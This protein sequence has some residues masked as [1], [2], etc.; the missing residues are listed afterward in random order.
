MA[1]GQ[2]A[3]VLVT[4]LQQAMAYAAIANGGTVYVPQVAKAFLNPDGSVASVVAPKVKSK[5]TPAEIAAIRSAAKSA[6]GQ[7]A[8]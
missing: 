4:P 8:A 5:L 6:K 7:A 1:I 3:Q 2:A